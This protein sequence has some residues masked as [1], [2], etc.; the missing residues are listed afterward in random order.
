MTSMHVPTLTVPPFRCAARCRASCTTSSPVA[1]LVLLLFSRPRPRSSVSRFVYYFL[2]QRSEE[3]D[4]LAEHLKVGLLASLH[5]SLPTGRVRMCAAAPASA[6]RS[7]GRPFLL[8]ASF[9]TV[10]LALCAQNEPLSVA[11]LRSLHTRCVLVPSFIALALR[12]R[13]QAF[14]VHFTA[15]DSLRGH[16]LLVSLASWSC[17]ACL[18]WLSF[19]AQ[20]RLPS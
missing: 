2:N 13:S 7:L 20:P 18:H 8:S 12:V 10:V 17:F 3:F 16:A 15:I 6:F 11:R 14:G 19:M 1:P 4:W 5:S 9:L